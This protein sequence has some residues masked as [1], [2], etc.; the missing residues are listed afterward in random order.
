MPNFHNVP[1]PILTKLRV[2]PD[3]MPASSTQQPQMEQQRHHAHYT[4]AK[5]KP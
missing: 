3:L 4:P 2:T 1:M 5:L